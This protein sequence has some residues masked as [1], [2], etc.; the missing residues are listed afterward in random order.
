M[1]ND[2][3]VQTDDF[4]NISVDNSK[5]KKNKSKFF[6]F[7]SENR[8]V[9]MASGIAI[10]IMIFVY[11]VYKFFPLGSETI[12]RM[13]LYHQYGP[14]FAEFYE[15]VKNLDSFLYSWC[16]GGGSSFVG[17]YLN[18]LSS[19]ANIVMLICG[20]ENMPEAIAIMVLLKNAA[21]AGTFAYFLKKMFKRNDITITGFGL[22]Y[23]FCGWFMAYYWNIMWIDGMVVFP[24][25]ILGLTYIIDGSH[26]PY[27]Y[28]ASL[29]F[30]MLTS[31]YMAYMICLFSVVY[32]IY[33]YFGKYELSTQNHIPQ[34][35]LRRS[36]YNRLPGEAKFK[37]FYR[38][39]LNSSF[40]TKGVTFAFW[41]VV[42]ALIAA[43]ALVPL[44]FILK[45]SSATG[46]SFPSDYSTYFNFFD[47]IANHLAGADPTIRSSG[48]DVLPNIYSGIL[49]LILAPLYFFSKKISFKEKVATAIL[50]AFCYFSFNINYLNFIWHGFHFPND[51]PYRWSFA[52]SF[53]LLY[54]AYK[55]LTLIDEYKPKQIGIVAI[56]VIGVAVLAQKITSKNVDDNVVLESIIFAAIYAMILIAYKQPKYFRPAIA[57]LLVCCIIT[58][59]LVVDTDNYVITQAKENYTNKLEDFNEVKAQVE[60]NDD[61]DSFYRME[62]SDLLTR[63]DASWYY[64][65]GVSIFSSMAYESVAKLQRYLGMYGNNVNSYTYNPQTAV[66]NGMWA[67]KYIYDTDNLIHNDKLYSYVTES[68]NDYF[69]VY[70]NKYTLPIAYCVDSSTDDMWNY[71]DSNPFNV[72]SSFF[73]LA[74]GVDGIFKT[75]KPTVSSS[76]N[77]NTISESD[78]SSGT[79]NFTKTTSGSYA[80]LELQLTPET[81]GNVY[82][83]M[84]SSQVSNIIAVTDA[85]TYNYNISTSYLLDLGHIEAGEDVFLTIEIPDDEKGNSGSFVLRSVIMDEDTYARG[86]NNIMNNGAL[87]VSDFDNGSHISGTIN[88]AKDSILY[89]SIPYDEGWSVKID[90][91]TLDKSE[92]I[93]LGGALLAFNITKGEH[94]IEFDY[95]P[96]GL[97]VGVCVS[98]VTILLLGIFI[99]LKRKNIITGKIRKKLTCSDFNPFDY[100]ETEEEINT[101]DSSENTVN[102]TNVELPDLEQVNNDTVE[103]QFPDF[104]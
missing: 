42:A 62:L 48:D 90:G 91:V 13:D 15:R 46:S 27:L 103:T 37:L 53:F 3:I 55:A 54:F 41:S 68:E 84:T 57:A 75:V 30:V 19:P 86:Y 29:C 6:A 88:V 67:L 97:I 94:T 45:S 69:T 81:S 20:H 34:Y 58:E 99:I 18:Y 92:Y 59:I 40:L 2:I 98:I 10:A 28:C 5:S 8:Y 12:L 56:A 11:M 65:N 102:D 23:A 1:D 36:E 44:Y 64:Y 74:S 89:T 80:N 79:I 50:F 60:A 39:C 32:F 85:K 31:Y 9:L 70:K 14:L 38:N 95:M 104:E 51:L 100:I 71:S 7:I 101:N 16:S 73:K 49:P 4:E 22:L 78:L 83:Y 33:Y 63:M 35:E 66:Y 24:L 72:Q 43:V 93:K 82:I 52:Y 96:Q 61:D 77:L 21:A 17:N 47:F 87:D 25:V 26:K 76:T